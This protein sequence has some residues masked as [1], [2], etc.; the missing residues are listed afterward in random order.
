MNKIEMT[1]EK[2]ASPMIENIEQQSTPD[3]IGQAEA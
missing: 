1:T 3:Y 2:A